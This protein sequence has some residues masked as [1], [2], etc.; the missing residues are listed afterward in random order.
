MIAAGFSL[1]CGDRGGDI[2][3]DVKKERLENY[4]TA[5]SVQDAFAQ[6]NVTPKDRFDALW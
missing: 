2:S 1:D 4:K 5:L 3:I 6:K